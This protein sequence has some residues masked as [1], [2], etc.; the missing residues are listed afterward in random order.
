MAELSDQNPLSRFSGLAEVYARCRPD[1]PRKL[2]DFLLSRCGLDADS[3]IVD[4]GCGT[5]I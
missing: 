5:G 2:I 3:L 4:V 1:Y